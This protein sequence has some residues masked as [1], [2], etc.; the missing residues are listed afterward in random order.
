MLT[1]KAPICCA[2]L[3]VALHPFIPKRCLKTLLFFFFC[4]CCPLLFSPFVTSISHKQ[5]A[6]SLSKI[7]VTKG[8]A[9]G[10]FVISKTGSHS[11]SGIAIS[12]KT[13]DNH[14][15]QNLPCSIISPFPLDEQT[16]YHLHG[17]ISK[18]SCPI[19]FRL[20]KIQDQTTRP[21]SELK[22]LS[23]FSF[24]KETFR[25]SL[26]QRF[27]KLFPDQDIGKFS[28]S[29]IIGTALPYKQKELFK[30][31][32]LSHLFSVSGWHFSLF[33]NTLF[34]LLGTLTPKRRCLLT[35]FL[36][37]LLNLIFPTSPSVLR[38]WFSSILF[39]LTPFTIGH[40]S[41][42]NR[43]GISFICCSLLF[44]IESPGLI[45]SFLAT[46]GILFFFSPLIRFFYYPWESLF[47]A[48]WFL[49]P[50]RFLFTALSISVS[51]QLFI[52]FPM[53]RMFKTLPLDGL[54][55]NLFYPSIVIPVFLLVPFSFFSPILSKVSASYIAWILDLPCL[56]APNIL[57]TLTSAPLP[58]EWI[59]LFSIFLFYLGVFL[60]IRKA[61]NTS[62]EHS[63]II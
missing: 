35:L 26:H 24:F 18:S 3:I 61:S 30:S 6:P 10:Y 34:F 8:L 60:S 27:L 47:G 58:L 22:N 51:A 29:L 14:S 57:I 7:R 46:L 16:L 4:F 21:Y 59:M 11:Y 19:T 36:L 50:L 55:F 2:L 5:R 12:L 45:L 44:P 33:A 32:G 13:R 43:L 49:F 1:H 15:F 63:V 42:L 62:V 38:T 39:C 23:S 53:I 37:S 48:R 28:S 41:S 20:S 17:I 54:I 56:H 25:T 52:I 31:K 40:C 9:S